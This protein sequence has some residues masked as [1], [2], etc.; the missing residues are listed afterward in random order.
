MRTARCADRRRR[1]QCR[2]T[3][4]TCAA[5]GAD[6]YA[7][8]ATSSM[9]P[10]G[11]GCSTARG[12]VAASA[13]AG[14]GDMILTCRREDHLPTSCRWKFEPAR[15][16]VRRRRPRGRMDYLGGA[17]GWRGGAVARTSSA[18]CAGPP[19]R[20]HACRREMIIGTAEHKASVRP[21]PLI[22]RAP[23]TSA[24]PRHRG[25]AVRTGHHCAM[26]V[27]NLLVA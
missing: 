2:H 17:W 5:L 8:P 18:C 6:F 1:R 20:S 14:G 25:D 3:R 13:V 16:H 27:M 4:A 21:S 22:G 10:P 9:R 12:T 24:D 11:S 7:S 26:P 15:Q 23:V 19:R